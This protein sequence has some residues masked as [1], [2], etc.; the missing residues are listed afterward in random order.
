MGKAMDGLDMQH[1]RGKN[2][3]RGWSLDWG[4][5]QWTG[6]GPNYEASWEGLENGWVGNG[7]ILHATSLDDLK[8]EIDA[9]IEEHPDAGK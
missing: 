9:F 3:Y 7:H 6:I 1:R 4:Y 5:N 2:S 8:K